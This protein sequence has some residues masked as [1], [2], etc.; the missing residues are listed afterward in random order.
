MKPQLIDS[1]T[2]A[3]FAAYKNDSDEVIR[4]ALDEGIWVVNVGTQ[5]DTSEGAIRTAEKYEEGVFAVI[6]LHPVHTGKSYH[7]EQELG[8]GEAAKAF[9]SRGEEFD[10]DVY[11]KLAEH[12]KVVAIGECGLDYYRMSEDSKGEQIKA[13]EG[14]IAVANA[15]NKPL[16][17]H[18]RDAF[19]DLIS[20][21]RKNKDKLKKDIP[22]IVH[23]FTGKK[24][25]AEELMDIGFYF[26][27]GGVITFT[28]DYDDTIKR[29]GLGR[30][31]LE[32]DAPYV[33]PVPFRGKRN[34]PL[35][36]KYTAEKLA[37]I[38][39]VDLDEVKKQ[40]TANARKVLS[41]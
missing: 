14:Q 33:A 12:D 10:F 35:Y 31:L 11:K 16:M 36:V 15:V 8:G 40:T 24:N 13:F 19:P 22:G 32:T 41:I 5:K 18:C 20:V 27:F 37:E 3:H 21:L 4:R 34:E 17:I 25:D 9:V 23:F 30:I 2:H 6:G 26:S 28:R 7:D 1:H 39:G 38:L 29:V